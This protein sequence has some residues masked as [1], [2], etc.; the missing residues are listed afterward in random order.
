VELA[1]REENVKIASERTLTDPHGT[2]RGSLRGIAKRLK[3]RTLTGVLRNLARI[4]RWIAPRRFLVELG[5]PFPPRSP[6][7]AVF[8]G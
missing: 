1:K 7:A 6:N 3:V 2:G 4:L 5:F 8:L